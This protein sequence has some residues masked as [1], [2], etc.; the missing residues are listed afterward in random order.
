MKKFHWDRNNNTILINA[1][2]L[3]GTTAVTSGLGFAFWWL[4]ARIFS[5]EAVGLASATISTMTL[6]G[7]FSILGLGTLLMGELPKQRGNESSLISTALIVVGVVGLCLGIGFAVVAPYL[8]TAFQE[9]GANLSNIILFAVGVS[10][11][12][13]TLVLDQTFIG[14]LRGEVQFYRNALFAGAKLIALYAASLWLSH[15]TGLTIYTTWIIGIGFSL[16]VLVVFALMK[17]MRP[18]RALLPQWGLLRK[19]G[20][21]ALKHHI[22]N[23][24]LEAPSLILPVLVTILLS[25]SVNAWFFVAWSLSGVANTAS[26]ALATTLYAVSSAQPSALAHKLRLTLA[27]AFAVCVLANCVLLFGSR[28]ILE[29]FGHSYSAQAAWSLRI[30]SLESFPFIIK[31]HYIA[32]SRIRGQL[33]RTIVITIATCFLELGGA[34]VGIH[35]GGLNGLSVGWSSAMC[36]EAICMARP[37]YRAIRIVQAPPQ[38][39]IEQ[40]ALDVEAIWSDSPLTSGKR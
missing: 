22:L 1:G 11:T 35:F 3:I 31:N 17:R 36:L 34:V 20:S 30:L 12:A 8:S 13:I 5:T 21:E 10:L 25:A 4:A 9:L 23:I 40:D 2:S 26:V 19:L 24:M 37:I 15:V 33:S 14:L 7:S 16:A 6:L 39:A 29:L 18:G 32:L 38:V 27:L 28:Q